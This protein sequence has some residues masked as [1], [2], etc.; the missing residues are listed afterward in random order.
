MRGNCQGDGGVEGRVDNVGGKE[1]RGDCEE[2]S[3]KYFP[4]KCFLLSFIGWELLDIEVLPNLLLGR[5]ER[6][7]ASEVRR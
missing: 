5:S 1:R 7:T 2:T 3:I 6:E 4:D